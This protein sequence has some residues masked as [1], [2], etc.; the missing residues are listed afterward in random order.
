MVLPK[1]NEM[2]SVFVK[3]SLLSSV[4]HW[5]ISAITSEDD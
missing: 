5:M 3:N 1:R 2:P 4:V